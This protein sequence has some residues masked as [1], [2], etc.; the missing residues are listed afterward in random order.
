MTNQ[1]SRTELLIGEEGLKKLKNSKVAVF[2]IGG[3]GS[4]VV[5][6]LV[7]AGIGSFLLI[8]KDEVDLNNLICYILGLFAV[9]FYPFLS[10][11]IV[12]LLILYCHWGR[13]FLSCF[14][15]YSIMER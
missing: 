9:P 1:F 12:G 3:V 14:P 11:I 4:Y 5:E 8:D 15:F 6:G 13:F 10:C 2:G 7:R